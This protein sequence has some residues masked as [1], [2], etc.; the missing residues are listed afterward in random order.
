MKKSTHWKQSVF[1]L[2]YPLD[3][4]KGDDLCGSVAS[5]KDKKN[6]RELNIKMS[7]NID[8]P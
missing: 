7:Y 3:V 1:Y 2:E 8:A 6:F 5:R 4:R